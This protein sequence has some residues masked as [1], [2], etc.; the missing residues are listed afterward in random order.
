MQLKKQNRIQKSQKNQITVGLNLQLYKSIKI[1]QE[2]NE[3]VTQKGR[4]KKIHHLAVL[5]T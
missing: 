1:T 4:K 3:H 2:A 5:E